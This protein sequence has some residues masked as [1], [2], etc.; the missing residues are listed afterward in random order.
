[1][2]RAIISL[3]GLL[4]LAG[5]TLRTTPPNSGITA[6]SFVK[7]D[8]ATNVIVPGIESTVP[9]EV[10]FEVGGTGQVL[11]NVSGV[12]TNLDAASGH[13]LTVS[14]TRLIGSSPDATQVYDIPA[15]GTANIALAA[16]YGESV[17]GSFQVLC[18]VGSDSENQ[19]EIGSIVMDAEEDFANSN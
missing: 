8:T 3:A 6:W 1:M 13:T 11:V 12:A 17:G 10:G 2:K 14:L 16:T 9:V 18:V 7:S 19:I 15:G 5:C 4:S